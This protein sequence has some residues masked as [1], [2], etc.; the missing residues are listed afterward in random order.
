M[1]QQIIGEWLEGKLLS[2]KYKFRDGLEFEQPWKYCKYPDRR[3]YTTLLE[4]LRPAG[5]ELI[6]ND[7]VPRPIPKG[8]YDVGEG[9]YSPQHKCIISAYDENKII[10]I[11]NEEEENWIIKNC[12]KAWDEP[13]GFRPDLYNHWT[14]GRKAS[15]ESILAKDESRR[16]RSTTASNYSRMSE[17]GE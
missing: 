12:R 4:G 5:R 7:V 6:T 11:P 3:F 10:R 13:T 9:F 16:K 15:V 2:W 8:C 17:V 14:T 1:G